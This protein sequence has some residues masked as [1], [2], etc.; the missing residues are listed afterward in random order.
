[1]WQELLGTDQVG[2]DDDFFDLGGHSLIAIRLMT[3]IKREM[4]VRLQ[5]ATLL[6]APTINA[7]AAL[8][9]AERPDLDDAA[10]GSAEDRPVAA[11]KVDSHI[12][13]INRKG[14]K[15]PLYVVHGAGGNVMF[16]LSLSRALGEDYPIFGFQAHG[17]NEDEIPDTSVEAMAERY[18]T[19]LRAKEPGPYLLAGY[20][21][22]GVVALEMANQLKALG[23]EVDHV[24]LFDSVPNGKEVPGKI[25]RWN[26][27]FNNARNRGP[28]EVAPYVRRRTKRQVRRVLR[29]KKV[30]SDEV[31]D[32]ARA[33][34]YRDD[35]DDGFV[36]LYFYFTATAAKYETGTYDVDVT[37]LKAGAVWAGQPE[38]YHWGQHIT[39]TVDVQI[40]PGD[41]QSMFFPEN[42]TALAGAVGAVLDRF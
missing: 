26:N 32:Q 9:R 27:I 39:G 5:L 25:G 14:E 36:N 34:G 11:P 38:D 18:V 19:E 2:L 8:I 15:R 6:E 7:L 29:S 30:V 24:I 28:M 41:H 16:L 31:A 4:S 40:V 12:Q 1:M 3:R 42:A 13:T 35:S 10:A 37:V 20:S 33:L 17:V 22:G 21:G 23:E